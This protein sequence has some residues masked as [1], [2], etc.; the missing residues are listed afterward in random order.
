MADNEETFDASRYSDEFKKW[1]NENRGNFDAD[2]TTPDGPQK[3]KEAKKKYDENQ[4]SGGGNGNGKGEGV[5]NKENKENKDE[6]PKTLDISQHKINGGEENTDKSWVEKKRESWKSW[7]ED[8]DIHNPPYIYD[9]D[10]EVKDGLRFDVYKTPQD[11]EDGKVAA[12]VE[13]TAPTK[14]SIETEEGKVPDYEF[15]AKLTK[16]AKEQD[17]VKAVS[18]KGDMTP[19]FQARLAASC[20]ENGLK[21]EGG[22]D[23]IDVNLLGNVSEDLKKKVEAFN[24][25]NK[26]AH[27]YK[28]L[29]EAKQKDVKEFKDKNPGKPCRVDLSTKIKPEDNISPELVALTY[30]AYVNAGAEVVGMDKIPQLKDSHGAIQTPDLQYFPEKARGVIVDFNYEARKKQIAGIRQSL[31]EKIVSGD[32]DALTNR[33]ERDDVAAERD[34]IRQKRKEGKEITADDR[35]FINAR[36]AAARARS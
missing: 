16:D 27:M 22:P 21:M 12:S 20:L 29:A 15:F 33:T 23:H 34:K 26:Y 9:E 4:N 8:K 35:K 13:Y 2:A 17:D 31:D 7:C 14:V 18:F 24:K 25:T 32:Q 19:E 30:A 5:E 28:E 11:K 6:K 1:Y 3:I 36:I 10:Q